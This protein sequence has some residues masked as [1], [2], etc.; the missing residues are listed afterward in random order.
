MMYINQ[1]YFLDEENAKKQFDYRFFQIKTFKELLQYSIS[2]DKLSV[3]Q[4]AEEKKL[5]S[6]TIHRILKNDEETIKIHNRNLEEYSL[7]FKIPKKIIEN[8]TKNISI[9]ETLKNYQNNQIIEKFDLYS[10]N[11]ATELIEYITSFNEINLIGQNFDFEPEGPIVERTKKILK[12]CREI[13]NHLPDFIYSNYISIVEYYLNKNKTLFDLGDF[14]GFISESDLESN[15]ESKITVLAEINKQLA[16]INKLDA[17]LFIGINPI[18]HF[19][20]ITE[21]GLDPKG[22]KSK[23]TTMEIES[24]NRLYI[25]VSTKNNDKDT[26]KGT[27]PM[28]TNLSNLSEQIKWVEDG[29]N[30]KSSLTPEEVLLMRIRKE[31][32]E[33]KNECRQAAFEMQTVMGTGYET[34]YYGDLEKK[35]KQLIDKYG[36]LIKKHNIDVEIYNYE[37]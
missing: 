28:V 21:D 11:K 6:T 8:L 1:K 36:E 2:K 15:V 34:L 17:K 32:D 19:N 31:V 13:K 12:M 5:S 33:F 10:F 29:I 22:N 27:A 23:L 37:Y 20:F 35:Q 30:S 16:H 3:N 18:L 4:W 24:R 9:L 25:L 7:A 14:E 26:I